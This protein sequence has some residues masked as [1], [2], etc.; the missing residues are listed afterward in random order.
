MLVVVVSPLAAAPLELAHQGRLFDD[1]GAPVDSTLDVTFSLYAQPTGGLA[2]WTE[3]QPVNFEDG[4]YSVTLGTEV[5][6]DADLFEVADYLGITLGGGPELAPRVPIT[7]VPYAFR[8]IVAEQCENADQLDGLSAT[9]FAP[10]VH[11]HTA[12]DIVGGTFDDSRLPVSVVRTSQISDVVRASPRVIYLKGN[13]SP[14][15]NGALLRTTLS[16]LSANPSSPV[17]IKLEPGM[18]DIGSLTLDL[19]AF[20]TLEGSG[21]QETTIFFVSSGA[22]ALRAG[23]GVVTTVRSLAVQAFGSGGTVTG[24]SVEGGVLTLD[25]VTVRVDGSAPTSNGVMVSSGTATL[26]ECSIKVLASSMTTCGVCA[27][28]ATLSMYDTDV[29]CTASSSGTATGVQF[30]GVVDIVGGSVTVTNGLNGIGVSTASSSVRRF[31]GVDISVASFGSSVGLRQTAGTIEPQDVD[32]DGFV[33]I[34]AD[35]NIDLRNSRISGSTSSIT[36]SSAVAVVR[37]GGCEIDGPVSRFPG[38][39]TK[40]VC[41]YGDEFDPLTATCDQEP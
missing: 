3:T 22:A 26:E 7:S 2:V 29:E 12:S 27:G 14:T 36:T 21:E 41:S 17:V 15:T 31:S 16:G 1:S 11:T 13:A 33:A 24:V 6:L 39:T 40:C 10:S 38:S 25:E 32:I 4:Y 37:A 8:A 5:P 23:I 19:R 9:D 30:S 28:S 35:G 20:V 34:D 18:Y